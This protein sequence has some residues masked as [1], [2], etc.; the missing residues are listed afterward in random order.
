MKEGS[1]F[2][3][4]AYAIERPNAYG[5]ACSTEASNPHPANSQPHTRLHRRALILGQKMDTGYDI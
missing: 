3:E 1:V 2:S 4:A 5:A